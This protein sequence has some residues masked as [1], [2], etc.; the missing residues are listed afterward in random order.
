V[1]QAG[2]QRLCVSFRHG[3]TPHAFTPTATITP[4]ST[5]QKARIT[6]APS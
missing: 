3:V 1:Q 4:T 6:R 5:N 2:N